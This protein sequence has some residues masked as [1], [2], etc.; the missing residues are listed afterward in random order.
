VVPASNPRR[1]KLPLT[2]HLRWSI[3]VSPFDRNCLDEAIKTFTLAVQTPGTL[4]TSSSDHH[5]Y[6]TGHFHC[7][8]NVQ[9]TPAEARL[10]QRPIVTFGRPVAGL[11]PDHAAT[12]RPQHHTH[13]RLQPGTKRGVDPERRHTVRS[14]HA[15]VV[16]IPISRCNPVRLRSRFDGRRRGDR[17]AALAVSVTGDSVSFSA[18]S[19]PPMGSGHVSP[20]AR[21]PPGS[22]SAAS[23]RISFQAP[24]RRHHAAVAGATTVPNHSGHVYNSGAGARRRYRQRSVNAGRPGNALLRE[25]GYHF[26]H[27][28]LAHTRAWRRRFVNGALP[29]PWRRRVTLNGKPAPCLHQV[30]L[31][32]TCCSR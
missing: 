11:T 21:T 25:P 7:F 29:I 3:S 22:R 17:R 15:V 28:V 24:T 31:R 30:P 12:P 8:P 16:R 20:T 19:A 26:R 27:R 14:G 10:L 9:L 4:L 13:Q 18:V 2:V 6:H 32:S 1:G 23:P 5:P